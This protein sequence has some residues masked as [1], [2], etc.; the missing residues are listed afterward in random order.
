MNLYSVW[1]YGTAS[2]DYYEAPGAHATHAGSPPVRARGALGAT[3]EQASW[4]LPVGAKKIGAG[5]LPRGKIAT[6]TPG[7]IAF[8]GVDLTDPG[9]VAAVL[10]L[11]YVAWKNRK[12]LR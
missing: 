6:K 2:Y 1:N 10:V 3:P 7:G 12:H 5:P 8:A 4:P 11:S 9:T